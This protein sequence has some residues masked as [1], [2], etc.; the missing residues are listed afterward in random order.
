[1]S[2]ASY[3]WN[4]QRI[5]FNDWH[6]DAFGVYEYLTRDQRHFFRFDLQ[7]VGGYVRVYILEQPS[8]AG[9]PTDSHSTHRLHDGAYHVC[10]ES[11]LQPDNVPDAL[12]WAV[13]W[14]EKTG[15]Y[16]DTG[17]AFS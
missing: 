5:R 7:P 15:R 3:D 17:A 11:G 10:I 6:N 8:Y 9:R 14:A 16:I 12:S 2:N 13:Y 4:G 1:M